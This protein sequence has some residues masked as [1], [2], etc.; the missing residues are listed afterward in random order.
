M[1][2]MSYFRTEAEALHLAVSSD[3]LSWTALNDNEPVWESTL[4]HASV[5]DP[6]IFRDNDG[7]Y[8]LFGTAGWTS[9]SI[10]HAISTDL[11]NWCGAELVPVM[12]NVAEVR[13]VW[14]PECFFDVENELYRIIWSSS[15]TEPNNEDDWNHRIWGTTTRDFKE[16]SPAEIYFDPGYSVIDA[17]V[18]RRNGLY[19][20]A[21]KDE[22]G[23]NKPDTP[24]KAIRI[25]TALL[26]TGP[27]SPP[28]GL[29][30]PTLTEGPTLFWRDGGWTMLY[31]LF[32]LSEDARFGA[33]HSVDG[34]N[35]LD[36]TQQCSF[37]PGPRHGSVIEWEDVTAKALGWSCEGKNRS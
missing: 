23:W 9:D 16:Y 30:T 13:N 6:V 17:T 36:I 4:E 27:W 31:D 7:A 32:D 5:R 28:S 1:Y 25:C 15:T 10:V 26:A 14:A 8:H 11:R 2:L 29:L 3:G 21:Y 22:R 37:P 35:W 33:A 24:N 20:M 12:K 18:V 34:D 19:L